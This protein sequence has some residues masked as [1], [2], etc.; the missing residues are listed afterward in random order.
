M[1][2]LSGNKHPSMQTIW[3]SGRCGEIIWRCAHYFVST[4]LW[5]QPHFTSVKARVSTSARPHFCLIARSKA[6][7]GPVLKCD[8]TSISSSPL[9]N[10]LH[11]RTPRTHSIL[12][13]PRPK[14]ATH[15][16]SPPTLRLPPS[17]WHFNPAKTCSV[18]S[19]SSPRLYS[20][21]FPTSFYSTC[22]TKWTS[23]RSSDSAKQA[24]SSSIL[25][26]RS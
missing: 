4:C 20:P 9:T 16:T 18:Q 14:Q 6:S 15:H 23:Q 5:L 10:T 21:N 12:N 7:T 3:R 19:R 13:T 24:G 26:Q 1:C 8:F 22:Y 2:S 25:A 17:T 11:H